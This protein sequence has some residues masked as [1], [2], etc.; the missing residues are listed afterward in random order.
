M[1]SLSATDNQTHLCAMAE[2]LEMF[3]KQ[4]F[5]DMLDQAENSD[6]VMVYLKENQ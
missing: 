5:F 3:N 4:E 6:E 2:L 1:F